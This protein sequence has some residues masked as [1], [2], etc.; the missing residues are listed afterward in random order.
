MICK[1][2]DADLFLGRKEDG[3]NLIWSEYHQRAIVDERLPP[4]EGSQPKIPRH[5][6]TTPIEAADIRARIIERGLTTR[7]RKAVAKPGHCACGCELIRDAEFDLDGNA[8]GKLTWLC[9]RCENA[10]E[11]GAVDDEG[12]VGE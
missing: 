3:L 4:P 6:P 8:T 9:I 1:P 10:T 12:R 5:R 2:T 7:D 11:I